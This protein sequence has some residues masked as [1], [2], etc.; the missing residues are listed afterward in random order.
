M[1]ILSELNGEECT[2]LAGS[3]FESLNAQGGSC[4]GTF[5]SDYD[6]LSCH[7]EGN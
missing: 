7:R 3:D 6:L 4:S 5:R 1:E 2:F